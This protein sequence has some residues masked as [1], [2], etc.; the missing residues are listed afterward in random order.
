[1]NDGEDNKRTEEELYLEE[2]YRDAQVNMPVIKQSPGVNP[3]RD[4]AKNIQAS[5]RALEAIQAASEK[6]EKAANEPEEEPPKIK[7]LKAEEEEAYLERLYKEAGLSEGDV[8]LFR[9]LLQESDYEFRKFHIP[10]SKTSPLKAACSTM[11]AVSALYFVFGIMFLVNIMNSARMNTHGVY[12]L[13]TF[14]IGAAVGAA[15]LPLT[16]REGSKLK[17]RAG[18]LMAV[19]A[20]CAAAAV[21]TGM[22]ITG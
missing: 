4:V 1:M 18:W 9:P 8:P 2:L 20:L 13:W 19:S 7:G 5:Q 3:A 11:R 17:R 10:E 12:A 14:V 21:F 15:G 22:R 6:L 16:I